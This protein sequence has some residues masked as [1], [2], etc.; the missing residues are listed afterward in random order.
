LKPDY[1]NIKVITNQF[2]QINQFQP[3]S[4]MSNIRSLVHF[5]GWVMPEKI[6]HGIEFRIWNNMG[7][8]LKKGASWGDVSVYN[9]T[10]MDE[11]FEE[12]RIAQERLKGRSTMDEAEPV[13][14]PQVQ[15]A[16]VQEPELVE[17]AAP[18]YIYTF[19]DEPEYKPVPVKPSV[20]KQTLAQKLE[21]FA[22]N[23]PLCLGCGTYCV[24]SKPPDGWSAG[25]R[26]RYCCLGCRDTSGK[27][28]ADRCQKHKPR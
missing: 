22:T 13:Q 20:K 21:K 10:E 26:K 4:N 14:L 5:D 2:Q 12:R 7:I 18:S 23:R 25:D 17:R 28:H 6:V 24:N 15:D 9:R 8:A 19:Q 16:K 11:V 3:N 27:K 1:I